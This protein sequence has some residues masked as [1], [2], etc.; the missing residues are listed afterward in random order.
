MFSLLK[1]K[2]VRNQEVECKNCCPFSLH[3]VAISDIGSVRSR[4]EDNFLFSGKIN[5]NSDKHIEF[6]NELRNIQA[7][8]HV[9]GVFDGM[10][11]G[12]YGDVASKITA[13]VFQDSIETINTNISKQSIDFIIR[14]AFQSSNDKIITQ[15]GN[16]NILGTTGTILC[17]CGS[18]YKLYHLGDSRAYLWRN[19]KLCQLSKDQT[20]AQMKIDSGL[21]SLDDPALEADKHKLTD[22]IGRDHTGRNTN[23][24]ESSWLP[25][26]SGDAFLLCSDG[27]YDMC[28]DSAIQDVL[29]S[30]TSLEEKTSQ[31]I[32][33]ALKNGGTDNISCILVLFDSE[34]P[35]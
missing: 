16:R 28:N 31:L 1:R 21:A 32:A 33:C 25:I 20:L 27:L 22:Y 15:K 30:G 6:S 26:H 13:E 10:G 3:A 5:T 9:F 34:L 23:P 8:F 14:R 4:N 19:S 35:K 17:T 18:E 11:G 7:A 12:E 2:K 29:E 24:F